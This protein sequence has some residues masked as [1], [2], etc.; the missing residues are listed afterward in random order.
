MDSLND[1]VCDL[2]ANTPHFSQRFD[3]VVH[4][5]GDSREQWASKVNVD[6]TR[7]LCK[8]LETM[9]PKQLVYISSVQVYGISSGTEIDE[10]TIPQPK[11]EYGKSKYQAEEYLRQWCNDHRVTL[12]ILRVPLIMGTGMKGTLRAMVNGIHNG[13]YFHFKGN[14][15]YRSI[16]HAIDV[17]R[18]SR[19][20][21]PI[22]G[23]YNISD[24]CHPSVYELGEAIAHRLGGKRIFTLPMGL[25]KFIAKIGDKCPVIPFSTTRMEQLTTT[26]TFNSDAISRIIDWQPID[27]V[28]YLRTN[29]YDESSI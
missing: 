7:N 11:T 3:L 15:A 13:Y 9:P 19:L 14:E 24:R 27:V 6:G 1:V 20:L 2:S 25:V 18:V 17:A 8:G 5:A 16:I 29:N 4:A 22:G 21:A 10:T 23:T 28:N 12:S 26:L